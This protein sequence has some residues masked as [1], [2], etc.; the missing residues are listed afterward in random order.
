MFTVYA[1]DA[2]SICNCQSD[3]QVRHILNRRAHSAFIRKRTKLFLR[4]L[5]TQL[6]KQNPDNIKPGA[7]SNPSH[8]KASSISPYTHCMR[9][10][11]YY[12]HSRK[13]EAFLQTAV[14]RFDAEM[15]EVTQHRQNDVGQ[16]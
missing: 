7:R 13:F 5:G 1:C 15:Q 12:Y 11:E 14:R 6:R 4:Y 3:A 8:K 10:T 9:K 2:F 16:R